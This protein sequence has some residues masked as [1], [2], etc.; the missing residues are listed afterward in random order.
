MEDEVL[1]NPSEDYTGEIWGWGKKYNL[2]SLKV[3]TTE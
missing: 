2:I 3:S 1:G